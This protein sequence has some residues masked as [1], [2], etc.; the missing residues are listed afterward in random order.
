[1]Y[2]QPVPGL[3]GVARVASL[4]GC[5]LVAMTSGTIYVSA[6]I[7]DIVVSTQTFFLQL[8]SGRFYRRGFASSE[9]VRYVAYSPQLGDRL[10][11]SNTQLNIIGYAAHGPSVSPYHDLVNV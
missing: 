6:F 4:I 9:S 3:F 7:I 1:M 5:I 10:H 11:A 2:S 8:Y